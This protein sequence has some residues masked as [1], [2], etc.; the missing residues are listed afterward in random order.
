MNELIIRATLTKVDHSGRT[1]YGHNGGVWEWTTTPLA[2][3][4]GYVPSE[5]YPGYSA[6]FFDDKHFVVV[7]PPC[8]LLPHHLFYSLPLSLPFFS[9]R[10]RRV[11]KRRQE[12]AY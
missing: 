1:L 2:G 4:P 9:G 11:V 12:N 6:D 7:C 8:F 10:M 3:Y 5:L